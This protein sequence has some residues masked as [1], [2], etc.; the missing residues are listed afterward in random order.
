MNSIIE[1]LIAELS[2]AFAPVPVRAERP[3][4]LPEAFVI[5]EWIGAGEADHIRSATVAVQTYAGR[6]VDALQMCETAI[7]AMQALP[8]KN[9]VTAV[10]LNSAYN[11][12]DEEEHMYRYQAIFDLTYY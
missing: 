1:Y 8:D 11:Y 9:R 12:T 6:M 2:E 4:N 7:E 5:V 10:E 3:E